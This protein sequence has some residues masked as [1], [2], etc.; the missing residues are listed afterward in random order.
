[1][2]KKMIGTVRLG[3]KVGKEVSL[4]DLRVIVT[5]TDGSCGLWGWPAVC[6]RLGVLPQDSITKFQLTFD[7]YY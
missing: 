6:G 2:I 4:E 5:C 7:Q 3:G 1:M